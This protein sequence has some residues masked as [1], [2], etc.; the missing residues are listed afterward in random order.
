MSRSNYINETIPTPVNFIRQGGDHCNPSPSHNNPCDLEE[1][2]E[3]LI[4]DLPEN[5]TV[6]EFLRK[7]PKHGLF[8]PLGKEVKVMQCWKCKAYGHR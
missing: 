2:P 1:H 8:Q 6:R 4:P 5:Q 7:A 3:D